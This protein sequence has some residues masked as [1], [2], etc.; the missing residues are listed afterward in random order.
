M[1]I[2][3]KYKQCLLRLS[4]L[5]VGDVVKKGSPSSIYYA[6]ITYLRAMGYCIGTRSKK[7]V[8]IKKTPYDGIIK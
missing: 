2:H 4:K 6:V 5:N 7:A 3:L 1:K 8:I